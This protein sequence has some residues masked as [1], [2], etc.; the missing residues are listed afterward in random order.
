MQALEDVHAI[1]E[2]KLDCAPSGFDVGCTVQVAPFQRSAS[3]TSTP[4]LSV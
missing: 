3:V 2:R 1:P 4:E